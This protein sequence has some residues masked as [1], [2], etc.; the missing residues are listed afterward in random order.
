MKLFQ[1]EKGQA[2]PL[3]MIAITI[4]AM[5]IPSFLSNV[6]TS[7]IGSRTFT[8]EMNTQYACDAGAEHAIWS[9]TNNSLAD[10]ITSVGDMVSYLLPETI[11]G[12]TPNITVS[13]G[14]E[15]LASEDFESGD[16]SGGNG[17]MDT[18]NYSGNASVTTSGTPY[19]GTYHMELRN[20]TGYA[21]RSIDLSREISANLQFYAKAN[22]FSPAAEVYLMVSSNGANWTTAYTWDDSD[23]DNQYHYYDIDL[24]G[25]QLSD[26]FWI[27]FDSNIDS[28]DYF[29]VD[30]VKIK[31][32]CTAYNTLA[33]DD[34]ESGDWSGGSGWLAD[35]Y[36][37]GDASVNATGTPCA[38]SYHLRLRDNTGNATRTVDLSGQATVQLQFYAKADNFEPGAEA[39]CLISSN[40]SDW[41][42]LYT[43]VNG[44]DDNQYHFYDID[45]TPYELSSEF[46]IS[47]QSNL[48]NEWDY[49]YIDNLVITSLQGY[50]IT[51]KASDGAVKA[52]V[53]INGSTANITSWYIR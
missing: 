20:N 3:V 27:A 4:G 47:F 53:E 48:A 12:L 11:N 28:N 38:G 37:T 52:V 2:L 44:D 6:G 43:W 9:L 49:F 10:N 16:W 35:W 17:W 33:S 8:Q 18:W 34:F 45:L 21:S 51:S 30:D 25:Y 32:I 13:N 22:S 24:S 23:A 26:E 50:G 29:Y 15:T 7:L 46:Y 40:G 31:W 41:S 5:V 39:Y 1:G 42:T 14:W 19:E 36:H